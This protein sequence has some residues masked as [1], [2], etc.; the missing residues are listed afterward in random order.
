MV[1]FI[2]FKRPIRL[3]PFQGRTLG[4]AVEKTDEMWSVAD[5]FRK[6]EPLIAAM[7]AFQHRKMAPFVPPTHPKKIGDQE[8]AM[9]DHVEV[10]TGWKIQEKVSEIHG[11]SSA[12]HS[13]LYKHSRTDAAGSKVFL[14]YDEDDNDVYRFIVLKDPEDGSFERPYLSLEKR[15]GMTDATARSMKRKIAK[16]VVAGWWGHSNT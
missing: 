13:I 14:P 1:K 15:K 6:R 4:G 11:K 10:K 12:F 7:L 9:Y 2:P 8:F 3:R 5:N 16:L